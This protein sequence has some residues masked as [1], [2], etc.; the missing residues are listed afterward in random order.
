MLLADSTHFPTSVISKSESFH[1]YATFQAEGPSRTSSKCI[2]PYVTECESDNLILSRKSPESGRQS[3]VH[4]NSAE[5]CDE[6]TA[7]LESDIRKLVVTFLND[8]K[9]ENRD[10]NNKEHP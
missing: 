3:Q 7:L 5:K 1:K 4:Q 6:V 10:K 9:D 8:K 2:T